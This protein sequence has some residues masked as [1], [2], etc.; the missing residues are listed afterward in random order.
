MREVWNKRWYIAVHAIVLLLMEGCLVWVYFGKD[1]LQLD[2]R[3]VLGMLLV[4][5]VL[6]LICA[7]FGGWNRSKKRQQSRLLDLFLTLSVT[8]VLWLSDRYSFFLWV[9]LFYP[10]GILLCEVIAAYRFL[11]DAD[12]ALD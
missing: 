4:T 11:F 5:A 10:V 1:F 2:Y 6:Y 8:L 9:S 12:G 7:H 3:W